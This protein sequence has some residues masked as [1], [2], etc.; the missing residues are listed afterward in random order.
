MIP[1][2]HRWKRVADNQCAWDQAVRDQPAELEPGHCRSE[3]AD[4]QRIEEIGAE[5]R[6]TLSSVGQARSGE[7]S[8]NERQHIKQRGEAERNEKCHQH[9]ARAFRCRSPLKA[10]IR[11]VEPDVS[12][13]NLGPHIDRSALTAS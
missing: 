3:R 10:H 5:P 1:L 6:T 13:R 12:D 2:D 4:P 11:S 7:G 8:T 9:A